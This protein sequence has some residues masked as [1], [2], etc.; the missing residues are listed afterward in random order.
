MWGW[1]NWRRLAK[2]QDWRYWFSLMM[3][4]FSAAQKGAIETSAKKSSSLP[5]T[6]DPFFKLSPY[7]IAQK[8][9]RRAGNSPE[10]FILQLNDIGLLAYRDQGDKRPS[11]ARTETIPEQISHI[12][13]YAVIHLPYPKGKGTITFR[14][15]DDAGRTRYEQAEQLQLTQGENFITPRTWLPLSNDRAGKWRLEVLIGGKLLARHLFNIYAID[16]GSVRRLMGD[17]G[18]L[19][20]L[21]A[22][23]LQRLRTPRDRVSLDDLLADQ[24]APED[25]STQPE[26]R[27]PR[28]RAIG[29]DRLR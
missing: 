20:P 21:L 13:P 9:I 8:A 7:E 16:S 28:S 27:A 11:V 18:E 1:K 29:D 6:E 24:N 3:R 22:K 10:D 5:Q 2:R 14:L 26:E 15:L 12:Q 23:N 25:E 4:F 19:D 17:D